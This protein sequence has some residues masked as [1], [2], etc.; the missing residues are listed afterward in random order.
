MPSSKSS[1]GPG[2][3]GASD[4]RRAPLLELLQAGLRAVDGR[5]CV[6]AALAGELP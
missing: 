2:L 6:R 3:A 5:A 4:P 1:A